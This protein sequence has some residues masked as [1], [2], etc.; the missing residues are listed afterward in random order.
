MCVYLV[1]KLVHDWL[2]LYNDFIRPLSNGG[3]KIKNE[4]ETDRQIGGQRMSEWARKKERERM[5]ERAREK[6]RERASEQTR[7]KEREREWE[8][9]R[10]RE[11]EEEGERMFFRSTKIRKDKKKKRIFFFIFFVFHQ[12]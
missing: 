12:D 4:T 10:E 1:I 2:D 9:G 7:E 5:S 6:E 8:R 11:G 3:D